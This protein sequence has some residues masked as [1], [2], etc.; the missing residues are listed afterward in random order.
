MALALIEGWP[1]DSKAYNK[2]VSKIMLEL[3]KTPQKNNCHIPQ[4]RVWCSQ[5]RICMCV[6]GS[7]KTGASNFQEF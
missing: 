3:N 2:L 7:I 6:R 5:K 4:F 1:K